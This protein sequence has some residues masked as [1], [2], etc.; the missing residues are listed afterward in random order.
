MT[1]SAPDRR[2]L[3]DTAAAYLEQTG[4]RVLD[5]DWRVSQGVIDIAATERQV[6]VVCQVKTRSRARRGP[7]LE[8]VGKA[9]RTRLR[10]LAVQWMNKHG[11]RF[12]QVRIDVVRVVHQ[13]G[14]G[15]AIEH[16]R[17]VG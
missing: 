7:P 13:R 11:V 6:F 8:T 15:V 17:G 4:F 16:T 12:E 5:R 14:E 2:S 10:R 9:K 3:L 1:A